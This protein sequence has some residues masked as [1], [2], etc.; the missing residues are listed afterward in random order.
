MEQISERIS[1]VWEH[2]DAQIL[3]KRLFFLPISY[4]ITISS[5][6]PLNNS[7][8]IVSLRDSTVKTI[9]PQIIELIGLLNCWVKLYPYMKNHSQICA[10]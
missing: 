6:Y 9:Y 4:H 2:T 1:E 10:F 5:L 7:R 8:F 3:A